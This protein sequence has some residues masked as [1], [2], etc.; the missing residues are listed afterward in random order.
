MFFHSHVQNSNTFL[1]HLQQDPRAPHHD[2]QSPARP[3]LGLHSYLPSPPCLRGPWTPAAPFLW[4]S[5]SSASQHSPWSP[6]NPSC[7]LFSPFF[8]GP[9]DTSP[10]QRT[11]NHPHS[12]W[13]RPSFT[14][15]PPN[16]T[17]LFTFHV[18]YATW[19][20]IC[21]LVLLVDNLSLQPECRTH[22]RGRKFPQ[23]NNSALHIKGRQIFN[24]YQLRPHFAK[25]TVIQQ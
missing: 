17:Y 5:S 23:A 22:L 18:P 10:P 21:C 9:G 16:W 6:L 19:H 24:S 7:G 20:G 4:C 11:L 25:D 15:Y 12:L 1:S 13:P 2:Q 8:P 14:L 3:G